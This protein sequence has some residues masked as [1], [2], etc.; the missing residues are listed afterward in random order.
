MLPKLAIDSIRTEIVA[1]GNT[2]YASCI[3]WICTLHSGD[4]P[5]WLVIFFIL[6][7]YQ[8]DVERAVTTTRTKVEGK[9][10]FDIN[11]NWLYQWK[12]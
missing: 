8:F 12:Y 11:V 6:I 2:M 4:T 7:E 9:D 10:N 1:G 5:F 3:L